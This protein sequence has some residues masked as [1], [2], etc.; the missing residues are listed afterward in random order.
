MNRPVPEVTMNVEVL[1]RLDLPEW[2]PPT[3]A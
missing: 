1:R 2:T 3:S